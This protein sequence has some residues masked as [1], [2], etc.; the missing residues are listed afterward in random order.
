MKR[1]NGFLI[2]K[3]RLII[4]L[5]GSVG[6]GS[7][8]VAD[9]LGKERD[10][11]VFSIT[12]E[13]LEFEAG[14]RGI[15]LTKG[16]RKKLQDIG[17]RLRKEDIK[18]GNSG[19]IL[20]R[21]AIDLLEKEKCTKNIVICSI[22]NQLEVEELKKYSN[23]YLIAID[24]SLSIRWKRKKNEQYNNEY[25]RFLRDDERDK[26]EGLKI[27]SKDGK[28]YYYGQQVQKCVDLA[29]IVIDNDMDF[30]DSEEMKEKLKNKIKQHLLVICKPGFRNPNNMEL[31]MNNAYCTSL[32]SRCQK[33]QVGAIIVKEEMEE[34]QL[35]N[36]SKDKMGGYYLISAGCNNVPEGQTDCFTKYKTCYRDKNKSILFD[37]IKHCPNCGQKLRK[38]GICSKKD[39]EYSKTKSDVRENFLLGKALDLCRSLHAEENAMLQISHLGGFSLKETTLYTTTFPCLLCAKKIIANRIRELVY[40]EP[41]PMEEA[42]EMLESAGVKLTKFEGVKAQ[43]FYKLFKDY[44]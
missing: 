27:K 25:A 35:K 43:A 17:N 19:G 23:S 40:V 8:W 12:R 16:R 4:A 7:S 6:S 1:R 22:K 10:F 38:E 26:D 21:K 31:L 3:D 30:N 29:D 14:K 18:A 28:I 13:I 41:Y 5:T 32:Q 2:E 20:I 9:F 42:R 44:H 11:R 39:C 37:K 15:D 33:R 34:I 36:N 24:T